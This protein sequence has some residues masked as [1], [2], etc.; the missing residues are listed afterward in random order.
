MHKA[1]KSGM[2]HKL[3]GRLRKQSF[4]NIQTKRGVEGVVL[5]QPWKHFPLDLGLLC[6]RECN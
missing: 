3:A 4:E 2:H 5:L 6:S 1:Q